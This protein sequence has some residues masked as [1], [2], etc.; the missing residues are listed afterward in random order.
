MWSDIFICF[1]GFPKKVS[2]ALGYFVKTKDRTDLAI[3]FIVG[4][5]VIC[6]M[7][8]VEFGKWNLSKGLFYSNKYTNYEHLEINT[9]SDTAEGGD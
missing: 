6:K 7:S 4:L 8:Q 5:L 9:K 1:R 3:N 2:Y